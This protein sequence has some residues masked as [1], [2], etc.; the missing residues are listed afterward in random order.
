MPDS[1]T[2]VGTMYPPQNPIAALS[3]IYGIQ[4]QQL[5]LKQGQQNLQTGQYTQ[6]SAQANAQQDQ[7]KA[8]EM[9]GISNLTKNAY[10]SGR[11][12]NSDGSFN[13]QKF[14]DDVAAV[15]PVNGQ[16]IAKD[17]TMRAGETYKNQQTLFNLSTSK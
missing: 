1:I 11:Y 8:S 15:A 17:A 9:Q 16:Q 12:A 13:S 2:P 10:T 3:S 14:A 4:Q 5:A 6:Q 7:I